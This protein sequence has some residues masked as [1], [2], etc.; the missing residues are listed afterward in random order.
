[1]VYSAYVRERARVFVL[2]W[3]AR[4]GAAAIA[5]SAAPPALGNGR[6][7]GA[8]QVVVEPGDPQHLALRSTFGLLDSRTGGS[9]I[10]W[11][12][13][14]S[15]FFGAVTYDPAIALGRKGIVLAGL[16]NGLSRGTEG[17]CEWERVKGALEGVYVVDLSVDRRGRALAV[18]S[19]PPPARARFA[20][21][22]DDGLTWRDVAL[23]EDFDPLTVD[24]APGL[25]ARVYVSGRVAFPQF[26]G[27]LRSDDG[28][29]TFTM[30]T[31]DLRGGRAAYIAA[32]DPVDAARVWVRV[33]GDG[34]DRLLVSTDAGTTFREVFAAAGPLFGFALSPDGLRVAVST[35]VDGL[36]VAR[37]ADHAFARLAAIDARCLAWSTDGL[38]AC[39]SEP[40][41][42][43][44]LALFP[45][46]AGPAE[47]RYRL[48]DTEPLECAPTTRTGRLCPGAWPEVA[49]RLGKTAATPDAGTPPRT[50]A[51]PPADASPNASPTPIDAGGCAFTSATVGGAG[52]LGGALALGALLAR[53]RRRARGLARG[54]RRASV[55][56]R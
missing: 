42:A 18:T 51:S 5:L 34:A 29:A 20:T 16:A 6:F 46:G 23:P 40:A 13:E 30:S 38:Y 11:I 54:D 52:A 19:E 55:A 26:G 2:G 28:G 21:S 45:G 3:L 9:S 33:T 12:C 24:A 32:V 48:R 17:G 10:R 15:A 53:R 22:D 47:P 35:P 37:I 31:F 4:L 43:F 27:M 36:S 8:N 1:M 25:P 44:S 50:P 49:A 39:G 14:E 56:R 41:D 7:P